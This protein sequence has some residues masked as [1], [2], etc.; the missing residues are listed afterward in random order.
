MHERLGSLSDREREVMGLFVE[1][2]T[3]R[4][5]ARLLAISPKTVE[6]H[7]LNIFNKMQVDSVPSLIRLLFDS[8]RSADTHLPRNAEVGRDLGD[9]SIPTQD[10]SERMR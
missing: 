8:Q 9:V 3:T 6:K 10:F 7:R 2:K 4:Q 1:A 5:V